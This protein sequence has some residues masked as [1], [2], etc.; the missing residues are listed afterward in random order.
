M[1]ATSPAA[2]SSPTEPDPPALDRLGEIE[3]P[4][5]VITGEHDQPSVTAGARVLADGTGA[6][7]IEIA[8]TAHVP[9]MERPAEFDAAVMPFLERSIAEAAIMSRR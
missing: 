8:G 1:P 5:L 7:L 9:S 4:L 6:E 3:P 2:R